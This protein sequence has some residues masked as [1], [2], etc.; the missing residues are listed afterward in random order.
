MF[1]IDQNL[2]QIAL[3]WSREK[4]GEIGELDSLDSEVTGRSVGRLLDGIGIC[5]I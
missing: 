4:L 1:N 5:C 3:I 2:F